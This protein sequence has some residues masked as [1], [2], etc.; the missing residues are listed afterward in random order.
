MS[1]TR[2]EQRALRAIN[3]A[4]TAE[5]PPLAA[6]LG[7]PA[8]SPRGQVLTGVAWAFVAVVAT[9]HVGGLI[10]SDVTLQ[11]AGGLLLMIFSLAI[12]VAGCPGRRPPI[13]WATP[14]AALVAVWAGC[15]LTRT[16]TVLRRRPLPRRTGE[17]R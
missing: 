13:S 6:L 9:L 1:L 10:L 14:R 2:Q 7:E 11:I 4:L 8:D 15:A 3:H 17:P 5:D 12:V 16:L